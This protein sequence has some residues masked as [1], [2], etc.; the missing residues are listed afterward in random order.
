MADKPKSITCPVCGREIGIGY[1][2]FKHMEYHIKRGEAEMAYD[3]N[4]KAIG[5]R[6]KVNSDN[7]PLFDKDR[8]S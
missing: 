5:Y 7:G 6:R 4:G 3:E 1:P 2:S 8:E